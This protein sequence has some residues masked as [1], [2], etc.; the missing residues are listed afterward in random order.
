MVDENEKKTKRN[1]A[2]RIGHKVTTADEDPL[3]PLTSSQSECERPSDPPHSALIGSAA[4]LIPSM[5]KFSVRDK[6]DAAAKRGFRVEF[7]TRMLNYVVLVFF[8][9]PLFLFAYRELH[10]HDEEG[11]AHYK[12]E[13]YIHVDTQ[14]VLSHLLDKPANRTTTQEASKT[15]SLKSPPSQGK[16]AAAGETG[17]LN[18]LEAVR[19]EGPKVF[20]QNAT[21]T[22]PDASSSSESSDRDPSEEKAESKVTPLTHASKKDPENHQRKRR[23]R[24]LSNHT[25]SVF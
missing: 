15:K 16:V 20:H 22:T 18:T 21:A 6:K 19:K 17:A 23:L 5:L 4:C 3:L 10:I 1:V 8:V 11:H 14:D 13:H 24:Q 2:V 25:V 7:P 9:L 12:A